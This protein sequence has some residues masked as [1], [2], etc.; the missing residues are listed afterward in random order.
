MSGLRRALISERAFGNEQA[1]QWL[2]RDVI[3][4]FPQANLA[5]WRATCY[6]DSVLAHENNENAARLLLEWET[7]F[8]STIDDVRDRADESITRAF[9][10]DDMWSPSSFERSAFRLA[11]AGDII[12]CQPSHIKQWPVTLIPR[13]G[14]AFCSL[15]NDVQV[16]QK[17]TFPQIALDAPEGGLNA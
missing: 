12:I 6:H 17:I 15:P 10:P 1:K 5:E 2:Y 4:E 9:I 16:F 7:A 11:K 8:D 3:A 14:P 13:S